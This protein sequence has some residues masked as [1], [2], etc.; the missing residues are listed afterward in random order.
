MGERK[1]PTPIDAEEYE[2][3]VQFVK[4][5]HGGTRGNLRTELEN[6]LRE[7]RE[8]YYNDGNDRLV[9]VEN[10]VATIKAMLAE[11]EVD[12]G[13]VIPSPDLSDA[14]PHA[15]AD[16]TDPSD[17]RM[18][19]PAAN[20][21]R[22]EKVDWI[23]QEIRDSYDGQIALKDVRKEIQDAYGFRDDTLDDY[24]DLIIDALDAEPDPR[25]PD[26]LLAW[27]DA[28]DEAWEIHEANQADDAGD[29]FD[30]LDDAEQGDPMDGD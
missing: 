6:A 10:D 20:Q 24:V 7:Y 9:R 21:P 8:S 26:R 15:H 30:R 2:A 18:E 4:D 19:K 28:L 22:G 16:Q 17:E 29:E 25:N 1:Q 12:G 3:F 5:V 11:G 14:S 23:V 27:G 13:E